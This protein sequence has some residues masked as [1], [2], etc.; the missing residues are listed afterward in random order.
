MEEKN[1]VLLEE[2]LWVGNWGGVGGRLGVRG[3]LVR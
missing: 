1:I 3:V 2:D